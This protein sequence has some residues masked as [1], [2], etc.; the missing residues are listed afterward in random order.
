MAKNADVQYVHSG[1]AV[2]IKIGDTAVI[3]ADTPSSMLTFTLA[4][5]YPATILVTTPITAMGRNRM[6][7]CSAERFWTSWKN[8]VDV[9]WNALKAAHVKNMDMQM[10]RNGK[11]C[12]TAFGISA[13]NPRFTCRFTQRENAEKRLM[14]VMSST[15]F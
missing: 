9:Y 15:M 3:I 12:H 14:D 8:K 13:G 5:K 4:T 1:D 6:D 7:A 11:F 10:N 2:A